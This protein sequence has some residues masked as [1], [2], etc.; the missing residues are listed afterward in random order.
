MPKCTP[1][2]CTGPRGIAAW[3]HSTGL[4][5]RTARS[6]ACSPCTA[7]TYLSTGDPLLLTVIAVDR[8]EGDRLIVLAR[9]Q[10]LRV[11]QRL[12]GHVVAL[13]I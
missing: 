4:S 10:A 3:A 11:G 8:V 6:S 5:A 12:T 1:P 7:A 2:P 13:L 9:P